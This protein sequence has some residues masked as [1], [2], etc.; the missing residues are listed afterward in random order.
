MQRA[1][2]SDG[3]GRVPEGKGD[4]SGSD[5]S[6]A[7]ASGF[8]RLQNS[9]VDAMHTE[10]PPTAVPAANLFQSGLFVDTM[11]RE[12]DAEGDARKA[13]SGGSGKSSGKSGGKSP[14]SPS[15]L[16][17]A[18]YDPSR[19]RSQSDERGANNDG[20]KMWNGF[21]VSGGGT[22]EFPAVV[23]DDA[24]FNDGGQN[25]GDRT[26]EK[27][28]NSQDVAQRK[29]DK[30]RPHKV[31]T[32]FTSTP[33][34]GS[35]R[36]VRCLKDVANGIF[37]NSGGGESPVT[38]AAR[39]MEENSVLSVER[40]RAKQERDML[41]AE[42]EHNKAQALLLQASNA[43]YEERVKQLEAMLRENTRG[44]GGV[45]RGSGGYVETGVNWGVAASE[46]EVAFDTHQNNAA[47][48]AP[49]HKSL[50][51][52]ASPVVSGLEGVSSG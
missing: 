9:D 19:S 31:S 52:N 5:K 42:Q 43:R 25:V 39:L 21:T 51:K 28:Q 38:A 18:P 15:P 47:G 2:A 24:T 14:Q 48:D 12:K 16:H 3:S 29:L 49:S 35:A 26:Q 30:H 22:G 7:F 33:G 1:H 27:K 4:R 13:R 17:R 11:V 34:P 8:A 32:S 36:G 44:S 46:K 20:L 41:L 50:S 40:R 23:P 6:N 37:T 10:T 45:T